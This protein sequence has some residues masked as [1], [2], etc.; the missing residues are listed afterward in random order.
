[1]SLGKELRLRMKMLEEVKRD[2]EDR[3]YDIARYVNPRRELL[4]DSQ[5]FDNKGHARGKSSYSGVP[6][7]ALSVWCDGMQGDA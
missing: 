6:A 3:D 4:R 5:K 2:Y 1:M 7:S